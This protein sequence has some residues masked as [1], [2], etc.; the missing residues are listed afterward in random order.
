MSALQKF[1]AEILSELEGDILSFGWL[2]Q[3]A[4]PDLKEEA[5]FDAAV[6]LVDS[7]TVVIGD[8]KSEGGIVIIEKW[9][10]TGSDMKKK[11]RDRVDSASDM[12]RDFCFWLQLAKHHALK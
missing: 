6:E 4:A 7:G 5:V 2:R 9:R 12:D 11:M 8:A 3:M 1:E 10:E